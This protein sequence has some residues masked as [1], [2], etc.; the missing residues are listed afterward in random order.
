MY[1]YTDVFRTP[2]VWVDAVTQNAWDTG[3]YPIN[4]NH[5]T[6]HINRYCKNLTLRCCQCTTPYLC[7]IHAT[8]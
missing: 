3:M 4:I 5:I 8:P 7:Y 1:F 6:C 2:Q